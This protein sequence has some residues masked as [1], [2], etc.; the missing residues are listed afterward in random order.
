MLR[1]Q[2]GVQDSYYIIGGDG[3][4]FSS[5]PDEDMYWLDTLYPEDPSV[6]IDVKEFVETSCV[7]KFHK[8]VLYSYETQRDLLPQIVSLAIHFNAVPVAIED[9][10]GSGETVVFDASKTW[11]GF[12]PAQS[13][14][15]ILDNYSATFAKDKLVKTNPGYSYAHD[16]PL[17]Y[18]LTGRIAYSVL[19]FAAENKIFTFFLPTGCVPFTDDHKV[20][21]RVIKTFS[22]DGG[23]GKP[24]TV[25]GYDNSV[26]L[27]GGDTYEAETNCV[28]E[29]NMGQVASHIPNIGFHLVGEKDPVA[30]LPFVPKERESKVYDASKVYVAIIVGDGDNF[31]HLKY[32]H[33]TYMDQRKEKCNENPESCFPM[34]WSMSPEAARSGRMADVVNNLFARMKSSGGDDR[35]VLPP[36]GSLYSY[37]G[38]MSDVGQEEYIE[39]MDEDLKNYGTRMSVHWEW[40]YDWMHT[41]KTY[42]PKW[43]SFTS[44]PRGFILTNVPYL[45]PM[46]LFGLKSDFR[47][48]NDSVYLFRP[49]EWRYSSQKGSL[50]PSEMAAKVNAFEPGYISPIYTTRDGSLDVVNMSFEMVDMLNDNVEV[51]DVETLLDL[52]VQ[53]HG[54]R[55]E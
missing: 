38:M 53:K 15:Y 18:T 37:P 3:G 20:H 55:N 1:T 40:F 41:V 36:S 4:Q 39:G 9:D 29:H 2:G 46:G 19:D 35:I 14:E 7:Y 11:D 26:P 10:L 28:R 8:I 32:S 17:N 50:S 5:N 21:E 22:S 6:E 24:I 47:V 44:E 30:D 54:A 51:V 42:F 31:W 33:H 45:F 25:F 23:Q 16:H 13:V 49:N 34:A 52:A 12:T 48:I 27:F 43:A